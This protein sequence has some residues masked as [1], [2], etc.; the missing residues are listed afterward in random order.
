SVRSRSVTT[1][2]AG[3]DA[4]V[5][6]TELVIEG[7]SA[8]GN[9]FSY[10]PDGLV[11]AGQGVPIPAASGLDQLNAAL[12]PAGI[13]LRLADARDVLGG[14]TAGAF[15]IRLAGQAPIPGTPPGIIRLRFGGASSSV[16]TGGGAPG[17]LPPI[18]VSGPSEEVVA[19]PAGG[20]PG[21]GSGPDS[22]LAGSA[23]PVPLSSGASPGAPAG[24]SDFGPDLS[25]P[26]AGLPDPVASPAADA[27]SGNDRSGGRPVSGLAQPILVPKDLGSDGFIFGTVMAAGVVILALA[28]LW[29]AKGLISS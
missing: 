8:A 13:E 28:V 23:R 4:P 27:G 2:R 7:G 11:V 14:A 22:S 6:T 19:P 9:T 12:E 29:R 26:P 15:E 20:E 24:T 1:Y 10:G 17:L 21:S 16:V 5:S 25:A 18:E 3:A